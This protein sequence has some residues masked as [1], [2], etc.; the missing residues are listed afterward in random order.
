MNK[1][2][3]GVA[4]LGLAWPWAASRAVAGNIGR[5]SAP[6]EVINSTIES[7]EDED[8]FVFETG[9]GAKLKATVKRTGGDLAPILELLDSDGNVVTAGLKS[10]SSTKASKLSGTLTVA[11]RLALRVRSAGGSGTV[12]LKWKLKPSKGGKWKKIDLG[13]DTVTEF[14]FPAVG[15]HSIDWSLKYKGFGDATVSRILDPRGEV[16]DFDEDLVVFSPKGNGE[17]A[18]GVELAGPGGDWSLEV[19]NNLEP[20]IMSLSVK[21][22]APKIPKVTVD[23]DPVEPTLADLQPVSGPCGLT[24]TLSGTGLDDDVRVYFGDEEGQVESVSGG[25]DVD[26]IV[27]FGTG[28]VDVMVVNADGQVAVLKSAYTYDALPTLDGFSPTVG[29][30]SGGQDL[31]ITGS[32]FETSV[33][34]FYTVRVGA[35][36]AFSV[37]VQDSTTITCKTPANVTGD[38]TVSLIDPCGNVVA[39]PGTFNYGTGLFIT[40]VRPSAVPAFGGVPVLVTGSGFSATDEVFVD[41][42]S[43]GSTPVLFGGQVIAHRIGSVPAHANGPVDVRVLAVNQVEDTREDAL[44]YFDFKDSTSTAIP[45]ATSNDDWGGVSA[46]AVDRDGDGV[47]DQIAITHTTLLPGSRPGTR[48]LENDGNG[49]FS[50]ITSTAMPPADGNEDFAGNTVFAGRLTS[51]SADDLYLS[52][53]GTGVEARTDSSSEEIIP[54]GRLLFASGASAFSS[55]ATTGANSKFTMPFFLHCTV[56]GS[57]SK[58]RLFDHDFRSVGGA[59]GDLDGDQDDDLVLVDERG[60]ADFAGAGTVAV[61]IGCNNGKVQYAG[62]TREDYGS[63]T[64]IILSGSNGG[65][66][67]RT[68]QLLDVNTSANED[69]RGVA[70]DIA[71][72]N[73]DFLNDIIVTHNEALTA[74]NGSPLPATRI[75]RQRNIG[76]SITYTRLSNMLPKPS[77]ANDDDWRGDAVAARDFTN[78]LYSDLVISLNDEPP[79][80]AVM[81]TRL[82]VQNSV[83]FTLN[84]VTAEVLDGLLPDGDD[85]RAKAILAVDIDG[86]GDQD[87]LLGTPDAVGA[88]N[89]RTRLLL[90]LGP[91][92]ETGNPV[93]IDGS[94]LL[95]DESSDAGNAVSLLAVDVDGDGDRDLILT[96]TFNSGNSGKRTRIFLQDR[97]APAE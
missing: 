68:E 93:F 58:C 27:P 14:D 63:A 28:T 53:A 30:G 4:V 43:V 49:T 80:D 5:E 32:G 19:S 21:V 69:F 48:I 88:G 37:S 29:A 7:P 94:A 79:G 50:D 38:Y 55:Q 78:D 75:F 17:K 36:D 23:L 65:L 52:R 64:R 31:T 86:D 25:T 67:D 70:A 51:D 18:K 62:Y 61:Y 8:L 77:T 10:K 71:D 54:W 13:A 60:I 1:L 11:G 15:G 12:S 81:S 83:N 24:R 26:V 96:D 6:N 47:V 84:D 40:S 76:V 22:K 33:Q 16:L 2:L 34:G 57:G 95:P 46:A 89:R 82:L 59:M 42:A 66:T 73:A 85:G 3:V 74:S 20:V 35:V 91:D 90:N 72:V 97:E 44:T 41:G 39:A 87:L 45:A 92:E 9:A 56:C